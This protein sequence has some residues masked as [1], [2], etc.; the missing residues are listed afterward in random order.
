MDYPSSGQPEPRS[1][2]RLPGWTAPKLPTGLKEFRPRGA[3]NCAI[4]TA[5]AQQAGVGGVYNRVD[6]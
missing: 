4:N 3:V 2:A 1:D 6:L 5:P